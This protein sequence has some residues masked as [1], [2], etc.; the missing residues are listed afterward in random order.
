MKFIADSMLGRLAR[1]LRLLGYD[2]AYSSHIDKSLLLRRSREEERILLTRD[3]HLVQVRGLSQYLLLADN[4][5]LEQFKKVVTTF[6]LFPSGKSPKSFMFPVIGRC[7]LCNTILEKISKEQAKEHV[8]EY[9][10]LTAE[11]IKKCPGCD[12]YYWEATHQERFR[13]RLIDILS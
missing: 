8:P 6:A 2:T 11:S 7:S 3:T 9:V 1:W 13:K 5:P 10:C 12:K 4:D